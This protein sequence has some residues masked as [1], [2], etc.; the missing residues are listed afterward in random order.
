MGFPD[1]SRLVAL[2][3]GF[4]AEIRIFMGC[5]GFWAIVGVVVV[6]WIQPALF[7]PESVVQADGQAFMTQSWGLHYGVIVG[8]LGDRAGMLVR[9]VPGFFVAP[10]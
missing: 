9:H 7:V 8:A 2:M 10:L 1:F 3:F 6:R 5:R 4:G